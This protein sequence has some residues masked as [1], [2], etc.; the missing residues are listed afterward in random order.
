MLYVTRQLQVS[1]IELGWLMSGYGIATMVSETILVRMIV[2]Y[3][4]EI[5]S[6]KLGLLAFS[7]QCFLISLSTR[8][9]L[10]Y[11]SIGFSMFSNLVYPS[12]SSLVSKVVGEN[13]QGEALGTLNGI[14]SMVINSLY[15]FIFFFCS[16]INC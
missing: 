4:G 13:E 9:E 15:R 6:I 16:K 11:V 8:I 1:A 10:I 7:L 3:I 2:P 12:I 5:N 14:K